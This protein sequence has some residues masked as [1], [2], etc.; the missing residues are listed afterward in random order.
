[1]TKAAVIQLISENSIEANFQQIEPLLK[2]AKEAGAE[3]VVLPEN[4]FFMGLHEKDKLGIAEN[5]GQGLIQD[6][7]RSLSKK[8]ALWIIA[9]TLPLRAV[10]NHV[11]AASLVFN[12]QGD[13]IAR[14]DKIHL[15]D[16]R[17]SEKELHQ[18][19]S[20]VE[21][22]NKIVVVETPIG[23]VGLS[24]CY[25]LRFPEL[26]QLLRQQAVEIF[27]IPSAFTAITGKAHWD[28]LLRARA[29]ENLCYVLAANQGGTHTNGRQ[30]HGHSMIVDPWGDIVAKQEQGP[31]VI[32]AV[33][34]RQRLHQLR[35]EF[36]CND[37]H[38]L[39]YNEN[40]CCPTKQVS[41]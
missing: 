27:S 31:G 30:T 11:R 37:H 38:V 41:S 36:P 23:K 16:V 15:F 21:P 20:T 10:N 6:K 22:G 26:Y 34:D 17:V 1:M 29:I 32:T 24:V 28:V 25:D 7:I 8:Y 40:L 35:S 5:F 4:C 13:C 18:E 19:S 3:L 39:A 33:I 12:D 14:Y 2:K 9:G